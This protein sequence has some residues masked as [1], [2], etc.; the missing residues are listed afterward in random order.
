MSGH[1]ERVG[2]TK[3]RLQED[4]LKYLLIQENLTFEIPVDGRKLVI[5]ATGPNSKPYMIGLQRAETILAKVSDGTFKYGIVGSDTVLETPLAN[6][7]TRDSLGFGKC[8]LC[9]AVPK[10]SPVRNPADLA[11]KTIVTTFPNILSIWLKEN[12]L[13]NVEVIFQKGGVE[14]A[15]ELYGVDAIC[16]L[17]ETGSSIIANGL[18][19]LET[20]SEFEAVIIEKEP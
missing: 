18:R 6:V 2:I 16:D 11:G 3:G 9:I 5:H 12:G 15:P 1:V 7:R 19:V 10:D 20:V 14:A 8:S 13:S 17:V 4:A